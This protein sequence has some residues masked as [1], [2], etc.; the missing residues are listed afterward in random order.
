MKLFGEKLKTLDKVCGKI[1][2]RKLETNLG[3]LGL[4]DAT[5]LKEDYKAN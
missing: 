3:K 1:I 5:Q 2:S 4:R